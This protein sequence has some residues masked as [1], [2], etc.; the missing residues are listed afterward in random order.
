MLML[1]WLCFALGI[2]GEGGD[3]GGGGGDGGVGGG[4][5]GGRTKRGRPIEEGG[6]WS[7]LEEVREET[8]IKNVCDEEKV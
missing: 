2:E 8:L 4:G 6:D 5:G 3:G 1:E 7:Y